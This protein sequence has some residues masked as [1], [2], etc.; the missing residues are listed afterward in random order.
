MKRRRIA[1]HDL[2][3][4]SILSDGCPKGWKVRHV[5]HRLAHLQVSESESEG[6]IVDAMR[7]C[8]TVTA[9]L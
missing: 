5:H 3:V 8:E 4:K 2:F 7:V 1:E 9:V 6:R